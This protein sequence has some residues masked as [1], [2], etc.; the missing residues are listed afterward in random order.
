M[1]KAKGDS[2]IRKVQFDKA[3]AGDNQMLLMLGKFRLGQIEKRSLEDV[4]NLFKLGDMVNELRN[5]PEASRIANSGGSSMETEQ[6]LLHKEF[7]GT[8]TEIQNELGAND[9][10]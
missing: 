7:Q 5:H 6:S 2:L 3:I 9:Y 4:S 1:K 8:E 10:C